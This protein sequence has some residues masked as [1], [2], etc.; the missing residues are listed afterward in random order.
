MLDGRQFQKRYLRRRAH[1]DGWTPV[2]GTPA[3]IDLG[4]PESVEALY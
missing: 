1:P 4:I 3:H 2:T